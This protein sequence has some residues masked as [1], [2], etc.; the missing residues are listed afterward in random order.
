MDLYLNM[1]VD[2]ELK[3]F[4]EEWCLVFFFLDEIYICRVYGNFD[5]MYEV[6]SVYYKKICIIVL[7][8]FKNF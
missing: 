6:G 5:M 4:N 1:L 2:C 8:E 7:G 3:C